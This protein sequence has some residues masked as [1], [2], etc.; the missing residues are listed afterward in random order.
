[1]LLLVSFPALVVP[2]VPLRGRE[3]VHVQALEDPPD[4]GDADVHVVVALEVHGDLGRPEV[5]VLPQVDDLADHLGS[6]RVGADLGPD[7]TPVG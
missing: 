1:L 2:L 6:G 7:L 5:V 4:A 3:P